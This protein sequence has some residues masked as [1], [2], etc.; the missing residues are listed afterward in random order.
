MDSVRYHNNTILL[1]IDSTLWSPMVYKNCKWFFS[2]ISLML[3]IKCEVKKSIINNFELYFMLF[4]K[5]LLVF[6]WKGY[7]IKSCW[8]IIPYYFRLTQFFLFYDIKVNL[9]YTISYSQLVGTVEYTDCFTSE[10]LSQRV[11]RIWY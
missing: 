6:K 4:L 9:F 8:E 3:S 1:V 10:R 7:E 2:S 11:S 5:I